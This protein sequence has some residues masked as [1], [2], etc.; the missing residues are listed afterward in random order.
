MRGT[1]GNAL[2]P[3]GAAAAEHGCAGFGLHARP[4]SVCFRTV[5]T[6]GLKRTLGHCD[7]LLF[8]KEKPGLS[9]SFEY[10]AGEFLN[11]AGRRA[12]RC[13]KVAARARVF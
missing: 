3:G 2:A 4:K 1:D 9:D 10:I 7:P 5:A 8:G 13:G 12:S 11:P 6:V